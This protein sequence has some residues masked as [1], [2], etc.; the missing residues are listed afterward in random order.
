M[1]GIS[2]ILCIGYENNQRSQ[3]FSTCLVDCSKWQAQNRLSFAWK[4]LFVV[5]EFENLMYF[6]IWVIEVSFTVLRVNISFK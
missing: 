6:L 4:F 2:S 3:S 5:L 1:L